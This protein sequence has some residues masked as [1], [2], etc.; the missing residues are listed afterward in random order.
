[1]GKQQTTKNMKP[2]VG[3]QQNYEGSVCNPKLETAMQAPWPGASVGGCMSVA[4]T[5]HFGFVGRTIFCR[6][7]RQDVAFK[8]T[9]NLFFKEA[10]IP[11]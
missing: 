6:L 5:E 4:L 1:M 7:R 10:E 8:R 3:I 2:N 9:K 11:T